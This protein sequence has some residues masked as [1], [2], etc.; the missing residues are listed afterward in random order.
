MHELDFK[1]KSDPDTG[2]VRP[3][4]PTFSRVA[5]ERFERVSRLKES[6]LR[7]SLFIVPPEWH[8]LRR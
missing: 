7:I 1:K 4:P 8:S 6:F 2:R 5:S 3:P